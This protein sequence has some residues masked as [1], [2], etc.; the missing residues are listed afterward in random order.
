M[1][2]NDPN[3]RPLSALG[4]EVARAG[5]S[6]RVASPAAS[7]SAPDQAQL[8][9]L[10]AYLTAALDDS[11]ARLEKLSSLAAAVLTNGYQ[12]DAPVVSDSIIRHSLQFG[13]AN[14]L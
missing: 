14:Y 12:V 6:G 11:A 10:G 3:G 5:R 2:I 9:N 13:G 8:S 4:S 7:P 1:R